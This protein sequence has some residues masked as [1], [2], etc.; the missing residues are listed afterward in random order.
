MALLAAH[1]CCPAGWNCRGQRTRPPRAVA[2][3]GAKII[4]VVLLSSL[5]AGDA[6]LLRQLEKIKERWKGTRTRSRSH[7]QRA[8]PLAVPEFIHSP[9]GSI[10]LR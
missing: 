1:H 6:E 9:G 3:F 2:L 5:K 7:Q 8:P 4:C 10:G